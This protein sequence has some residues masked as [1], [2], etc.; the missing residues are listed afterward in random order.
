MNRKGKHSHIQGWEKIII[1]EKKPETPYTFQK[2]E[3]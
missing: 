3:I 1:G 2:H